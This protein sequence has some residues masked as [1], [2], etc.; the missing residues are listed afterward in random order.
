MAQSPLTATCVWRLTPELVIALDDR[1]GEPVDAYVNGS[2]VWLREDGPGQTMIEWRLH[3]VPGYQRPTMLTVYDTFSTIA[4]CL[5][6]GDDPPAPAHELWDGL[7]AFA[8]YGDDLEPAV[9]AAAATEALG[10]A[11]DATGLADHQT[12]GDQWERS[13]GRLSIV[14]ALLDQLDPS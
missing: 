7:E 3:P 5:A 4:L 12:I 1:F 14:H 2:Q 13:K 6:R 10:I 9:L 8:A 11:P